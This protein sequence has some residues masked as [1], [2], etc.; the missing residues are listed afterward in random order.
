MKR[1][2]IGPVIATCVGCGCDDDHACPGG[3]TWLRV[4]YEKGL[5]VCSRCPEHE[6]RWDSGDRSLWF[7]EPI[8]QEEPEDDWDQDSGL[9][10]PGDEAF[11]DT[12][13][14]LRRR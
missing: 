6:V 9:I 1:Q 11:D 3:C 2:V 13:T 10:L 4:D 7:G 8:E 14:E 5:G 12:L